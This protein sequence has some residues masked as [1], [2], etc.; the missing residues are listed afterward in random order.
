MTDISNGNNL[1]NTNSA[2]LTRTSFNQLSSNQ[3]ATTLRGENSLGNTQLDRRDQGQR[4]FEETRDIFNDRRNQQRQSVLDNPPNPLRTPNPFQNTGLTEQQRNIVTDTLSQL[5]RDNITAQ[6][7][8]NVANVFRENN[9]QPS[10]ELTTEIQRQ[11][12]DVEQFNIQSQADERRS[13]RE[14]FLDTNQNTIRTQLQ[15][16]ERFQQINN[17][18]RQLFENPNDSET[19]NQLSSLLESVR[20]NSSS[21][22]GNI[23]DVFA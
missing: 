19:N 10:R 17:L 3:R 23:V 12:F 8:R 9:I 18:S 22:R 20:G 14:I 16:N 1:N 13:N 5:D 21:S 6:D 4:N 2:Q 15:G 7:S 11:G